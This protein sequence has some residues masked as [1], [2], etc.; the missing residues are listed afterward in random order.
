MSS[1]ID[2]VSSQLFSE[3]CFRIDFVDLTI[4][5]RAMNQPLAVATAAALPLPPPPTNATEIAAAAV[6]SPAKQRKRRFDPS[7]KKRGPK[8][9][10]K[11]GEEKTKQDW[12]RI[13]QIYVELPNNVKER[14]M[15]MR[16]FLASSL[17]PSTFTGT[18][19]ELVSFARYVKQFHAGDL[20]P[21]RHKRQRKRELKPLE[22]QL[23][24]HLKR[25]GLQSWASIRAKALEFATDLGFTD[26]KASTGWISK[27]L[28]RY[29]LQ[30][31]VQNNRAPPQFSTVKEHF[32]DLTRYC[33]AHRLPASTRA[34]LDQLKTEIGDDYKRRVK[35]N[36]HFKNSLT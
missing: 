14:K 24:K 11:R 20:E 32:D 26:F 17:S 29:D 12:Y 1:S 16:A 6:A 5:T 28:Q 7:S 2:V 19:S 22:I 13:C 35:E 30:H 9:G 27:F 34:L 3:V 4:R 33:R 25:S 23:E 36:T 8:T 10:S 18:K 31:V 15:S 21:T